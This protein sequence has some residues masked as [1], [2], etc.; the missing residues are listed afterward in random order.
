MPA[1]GQSPRLPSAPRGREMAA[2]P[3]A[4]LSGAAGGGRP[5]AGSLLGGARCGASGAAPSPAGRGREPG[6]ARQEPQPRSSPGDGSGRATPVRSGRWPGAGRA[7]QWYGREGGR[8]RAGGGLSLERLRLSGVR[9]PGAPLR[10]RRRGTAAPR[11]PPPRPCPAA[12]PSL[13]LAGPSFLP[14]LRFDLIFSFPG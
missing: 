13:S 4:R 5:G 7:P 14:D 10:R 2:A 1:G 9:V 6:R 11:P 3:R 12:P 8:R